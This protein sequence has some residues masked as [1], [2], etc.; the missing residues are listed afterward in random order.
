MT[1]ERPGPE[2]A[3]LVAGTSVNRP[4]RVITYAWG[5]KYVDTL[6]SFALPALLAPGNLP[7]IASVAPCE[8]II[9]TQEKFF[10]TVNVNRVIL[11]LKEICT[12]RL[13][14]LDDLICAPDKYGISLT[15]VLHRGFSDLGP[16]MTEAWQIFLN[17]DFIVADGGLRTLLER[18]QR[19][20]RL[21]ASPSYCVNSKEVLPLLRQ[22]LDP[23]SAALTVAPREMAKLVLDHRHQ[24]IRGKTVNQSRFH[25]RYVD[26]FYWEVDDSTLLGHQMPIAIVGMR[27]E[28]YVE[29]PNSYWDYGLMREFCPDAEPCIL[30]DSDDFLMLELRD[31]EVAQD[32]LVPGPINPKEIGERMIVWVT[33]YQRDFAR[34]PL[35]LHAKDLPPQT[36]DARAK[37]NAVKDEIL[38]HSPLYLPSHID[39]PQW[40]YHRAGFM[41]A[42]HK[43]LSERLGPLTETSAPPES[44]SDLDKA[45]WR[46]DGQRKIEARRVAELMESL[47]RE[48]Q[49]LCDAIDRLDWPVREHNEAIDPRFFAALAVARR[50]SAGSSATSKPHLQP[51]AAYKADYVSF[52]DAARAALG[53]YDECVASFTAEATSR[54]AQYQAEY[55]RLAPPAIGSAAIPVLKAWHGPKGRGDTSPASPPVRFVRWLRRQIWGELPRVTRLHPYSSALQPIVRIVDAAA[56]GGARDVL[57]AGQGSGIVDKVADRLPGLHLATL[58]SDLMSVNFRHTLGGSAKFDLCV[59]ELSAADLCAFSDLYETV[60]PLLTRNGKFVGLLLNTRGGPVSIPEHLLGKRAGSVKGKV[61]FCGYRKI[62]DPR[63]RQSDRRLGAGAYAALRKW[64]LARFAHSTTFLVAVRLVRLVFLAPVG[65]TR[66]VSVAW[67]AATSP[68]ASFETSIGAVAAGP[69]LCTSLTIEITQEIVGSSEES[70]GNCLP[71]VA[72]RLEKVA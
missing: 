4:V 14:S 39:H 69:V 30:G 44:F 43:Y 29:E 37:L 5:D 7:S 42:R 57:F 65:L 22:R 72:E 11:R 71:D 40:T 52:A 60:R 50:T 47:D 34:Y 20:E 46:L 61:H 8:L 13:V 26:Q 19:G 6:L 70:E 45:W 55:D 56:A 53:H 12:V 17:A 63:P 1:H 54:L 25:L 64:A 27:P 18:L 10:D 67:Q 38:A 2:K 41:Q 58:V 68:A 9:L 16:A 48:F 31:N 32:Q 21:V 23:A 49:Q 36:H 51:I 59:C 66:V 15:Y 35:T 3:A 33:P 62:V 24:T 28:R